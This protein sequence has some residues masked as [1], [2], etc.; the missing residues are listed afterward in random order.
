MIF[1]AGC[2]KNPVATYVALFRLVQIGLETEAGGFHLLTTV[3]GSGLPRVP[4][5]DL[6]QRGHRWQPQRVS[7]CSII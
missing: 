6:Y 7:R 2:R 3:Y 4:G 5:L 1:F